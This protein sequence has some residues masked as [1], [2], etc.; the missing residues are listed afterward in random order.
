M[1]R[2]SRSS[3]GPAELV[4]AVITAESVSRD[5]IPALLGLLDEGDRQVRLGAATAL[6]VVAESHPDA[7]GHVAG[8]LADRT[9]DGDGLAAG[10]ALEYLAARYPETVESA[11]D[12][13]TT[14]RGDGHRL[15]RSGPTRHG[16]GNRDIG[17]TSV[18]G[19]GP[20]GGRRVYTD[21]DDEDGTAPDAA[22]D[23]D[24]GRTIGQRPRAN[25]SEW[26]SLVEYESE[27]DRLTVLAPRNRRR[28]AD[29]YR[30][31]GVV[32]NEERAV[33][34]RLLRGGDADV[35]AFDRDL[36]SRLSDWVSVGDVDNVVSVYDWHADPQLWA[37]TEYTE[38]TLA[39]RDRFE[40]AEAAW[41]AARLAEAVATLHER[42]LVHAGIDPESVA[43]YG[44]VLR[45]G[46]RQPPLLDNVGLLH[47]YR[48]YFDPS[49][50]LDPRY[51]A[52]E[53]FE[54]R[55]GQVDHATDIYGL[56]AVCHRLFTGRHPY[57]GT[58]GAVREQVV[59]AEPPTPSDVADVPP[60]V[61]D[62]VGKAMATGKLARYETAAHL[63]QELRGLATPGADD[64]R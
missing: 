15:E 13:S 37:A 22:P 36:R 35:P 29:T 19:S 28:Y 20:A 61:D 8:R 21:E 54:R 59:D 11:V 49:L 16:L 51:A 33:A 38:T 64:G 23:D 12:D 32:N 41:H 2:D 14:D 50:F 4:A 17:R 62:I 47:V 46:E 31:L 30:T 44:N 40:P 58:F 53:Y 9:G 48:R 63:T 43:Y 55:F 25:E 3:P 56:G 10:L 24:E 6:C 39:E 18:A 34:L 1:T 5:R 45:E 57:T 42:G 52:P 27:F 7:A 60:A 26:L